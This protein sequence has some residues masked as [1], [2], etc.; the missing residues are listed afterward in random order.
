M[1]FVTKR[2]AAFTPASIPNSTG[3]S[4]QPQA[5]AMSET[6]IYKRGMEWF[7][8][9]YSNKADTLFN[10]ECAAAARRNPSP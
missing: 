7:A 3:D 6:M 9:T 10:L 5:G 4:G 1:F 8:A 2:N